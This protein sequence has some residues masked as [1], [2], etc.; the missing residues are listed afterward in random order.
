MRSILPENGV[1]TTNEND[2][3]EKWGDT[4]LKKVIY[5]LYIGIV[6]STTDKVQRN[7]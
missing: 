2:V 5:D 4:E 7:V 3:T 1:C 6:T